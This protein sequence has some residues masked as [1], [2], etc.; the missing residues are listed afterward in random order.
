M[1]TA[2]NTK[3]KREGL[4]EGEKRGRVQGKEEGKREIARNLL[5]AGVALDIIIQTTGLPEREIKNLCAEY[6]Q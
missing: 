6:I 1:R 5:Q 3:G 2:S 4:I